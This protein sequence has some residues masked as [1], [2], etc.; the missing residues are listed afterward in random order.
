MGYE[1]PI[2]DTIDGTHTNYNECLEA[3][4][5]EVRGHSAAAAAAAVHCA[6]HHLWRYRG[7]LQQILLAAVAPF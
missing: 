1:S 6:V 5:D 3:V 7:L 4:L 2:W